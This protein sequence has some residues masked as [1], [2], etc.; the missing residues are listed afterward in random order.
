MSCCLVQS[1]YIHILE[2]LVVFAMFLLHL[3]T[4]TSSPLE[5]SIVF[6]LAI[7]LLKRHVYNLTTHKIVFSRDVHFCESIFPFSSSSPSKPSSSAPSLFPSF[8]DSYT[9]VDHDPDSLVS[10]PVVPSFT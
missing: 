4:E 7:L 3:T 5:L 2:P 6:S 9:S 8:P 1:H 10:N